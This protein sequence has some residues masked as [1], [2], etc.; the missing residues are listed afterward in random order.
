MHVCCVLQVHLSHCVWMPE[1]KFNLALLAKT[2]KALKM[3]LLYG[4][5]QDSFFFFLENIYDIVFSIYWGVADK[6]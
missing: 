3:E 2:D 4:S 5:S 1:P 6:I